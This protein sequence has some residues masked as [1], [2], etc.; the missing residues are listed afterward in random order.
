MTMKGG[1]SDVLYKDDGRLKMA[2][3][4]QR[5]WPGVVRTERRFMRPQHVVKDGWRKFDTPLKRKKDINLDKLENKF[6]I[7]LKQVAPEV[8][9]KLIQGFLDEQK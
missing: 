2:R 8:K 7:K 4:L 1:N 9:S 5:V 3:S 6:D